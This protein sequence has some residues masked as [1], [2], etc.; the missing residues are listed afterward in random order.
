M[1]KLIKSFKARMKKEGRFYKWFHKTY[2]NKSM[3][4]PYF[5]IQLNEP[6]RMSDDL[7]NAIK[8]YLED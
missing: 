7:I 1:E 6:D 3:S 2:L 5:I 4:Y 8:K